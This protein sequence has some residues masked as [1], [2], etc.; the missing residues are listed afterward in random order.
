MKKRLDAAHFFDWSAAKNLDWST[1]QFQDSSVSKRAERAERELD[2]RYVALL[3]VVA[4][5]PNERIKGRSRP[6]IP[7]YV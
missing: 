6:I 1:V 3:D 7:S 4:E 2:P 5:G